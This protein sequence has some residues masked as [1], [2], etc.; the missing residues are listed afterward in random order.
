MK[1]PNELDRRNFLKRAG[2]VAFLSAAAIKA[3]SRAET[4][5][6]PPPPI[7]C[8]EGTC[9][10]LPPPSCAPSCCGPLIPPD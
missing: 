6:P 1:P 2:T 10:L 4:Q 3:A 9:G 8:C 7:A 5:G